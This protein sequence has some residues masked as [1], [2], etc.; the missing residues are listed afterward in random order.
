[1]VAYHTG[2]GPRAPAAHVHA[3]LRRRP[4]LGATAAVV[5][6]DAGAQCLSGGGRR[7]GSAI[8][9]WPGRGQPRWPAGH[10]GTRGFRQTT[11]AAPGPTCACRTPP[12]RALPFDRRLSLSHGDYMELSVDGDGVN[13]VIWGG[14]QLHMA[15]AGHGI[16]RVNIERQVVPSMVVTPSAGYPPW[17]TGGSTAMLFG[18]RWPLTTL[19]GDIPPFSCW[20]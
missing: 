20:R 13:H 19:S 7:A 16:A 17:H 12:R 10:V 8:F 11:A 9:V 4:D 1:M 3:A 18:R 2:D 6:R 14:A 5:C 15:P